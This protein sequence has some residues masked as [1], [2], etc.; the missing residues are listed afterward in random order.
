MGKPQASQMNVAA[1]QAGASSRCQAQTPG[2]IIPTGAPGVAVVAGTGATSESATGQ[3]AGATSEKTGSGAQ[4]T[5]KQPVA[6]AASN[7]QGTQRKS[8]SGRGK[9]AKGRAA[10]RPQSTRSRRRKVA[11]PKPVQAAAPTP[12]PRP[13]AK[14]KPAPKPKSGGDEV[15]DLL[16]GLNSGGGSSPKAR[17]AA[18]RR[19]VESAPAA[20][21]LYLRSWVSETLCP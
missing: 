14:T 3:A 16:S 2:T 19:P 5:Q 17:P 12:A 18:R 4:A 13:V 15:D 8:R 20:D 9:A 21:P 11:K 6:V 1:G 10:K 7:R